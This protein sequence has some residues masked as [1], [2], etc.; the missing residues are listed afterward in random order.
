ML[1]NQQELVFSKY[2]ALY[3]ILIPEDDI[4]RQIKELVDF[5][6]VLDEI[7]ENYSDSMGRTAENPIRMFKYLMLKDM[8][9][10][11]DKDLIK[12]TRTDMAFKF[13]L[14]LSPEE[15]NLIHPTTLTKFRRLRLKNEDLLDKLIQKTIELAIEKGIDLG[16][17][18]IVDATHTHAR[19]RQRSMEEVLL[20]RAKRLR[21]DVYQVDE[22]MKV[23]FPKKLVEPTLEEVIAYCESIAQVVESHPQLCVRENISKRLNYLREGLSDTESALDEAGDSQART[24][25]KTKDDSFFGY[26]T[27]IGL[28][29]NRLITAAVITSGEKPDGSELQRLIEK[30]QSSGMEVSEVIGD[31]AYS[32][33]DNLRYAKEN[34]IKLIAKLN[35][36]IS[37]GVRQ[38]DDDFAFNKDADLFVC[39][40]GHLAIRKAKTG[41][42]KT[43]KNQTMTYYFDI[44]KCKVCPRKS[45]C[46]KEGAKSKSY[47]VSI[48]S[49][50]HLE[51]KTFEETEYFK[52][53][54]RQRYMIEAKNSELKN[55]HGYD[56]AI[57][58]GIFGIRI[59]GAVS[60]FN[61]NIKRILTILSEKSK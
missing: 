58:S 60:I 34:E 18:L 41:T 57:S 31:T 45:G 22:S 8:N 14:D 16:K 3:D 43:N 17:A 48:K 52:D 20:E 24:G 21:R 2:L 1:N 47:S 35:P 19:Y 50:L 32:G 11:S 6:F 37:N 4:H 61:V 30:S 29:E 39:P 56:V 44:E 15:T 40:T 54:N 9:E 42:K 36:V 13:F 28:S 23:H 55:Q 25:Y 38:A 12:R 7:T 53:R 26:K 49:D 59:Q 27:H 33:K 46:Y 10:L 51:Q 5:S